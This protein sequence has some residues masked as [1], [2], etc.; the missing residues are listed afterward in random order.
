M[1]QREASLHHLCV[2]L[3]WTPHP[4]IVTFYKGEW[5]DIKGSSKCIVLI[6]DA[7]DAELVE[8][9]ERKDEEWSERQ[10]R[11]NQRLFVLVV[12]F[13]QA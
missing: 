10:K 7:Q 13:F 6:F 8:K 5:Y 12:L 1:T 11:T 3:R 2:Q 9:Q 4:V